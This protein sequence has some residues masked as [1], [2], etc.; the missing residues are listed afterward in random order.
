[1]A[2]T[3]GR[4]PSRCSVAISQAEAVLTMMVLGREAVRPFINTAR[5]RRKRPG[6]GSLL[7]V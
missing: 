5:K 6:E 3:P 1:M 7:L 2:A 4:L